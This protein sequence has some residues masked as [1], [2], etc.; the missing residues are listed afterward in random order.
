MAVW[1]LYE[2]RIASICAEWDRAEKY[3]KL[4]E[5]IGGKVVFPAV[6][7]LRY[8]GRRIIEALHHI[9]AKSPDHNMVERPSLQIPPGI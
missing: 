7:E 3:I 8:A 6:A 5:Q 1:K 2:A 4:A 9:A